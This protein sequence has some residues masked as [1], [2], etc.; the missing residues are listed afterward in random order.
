MNKNVIDL[1]DQML[2]D[3][4]DEANDIVNSIGVHLQNARSKSDPAI[5]TSIQR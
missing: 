4:R 2:A 5:L 1:Y 3:F